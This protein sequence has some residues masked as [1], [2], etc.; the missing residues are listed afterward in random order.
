[1]NYLKTNLT[2]PTATFVSL[3]ALTLSIGMQQVKALD[4]SKKVSTQTPSPSLPSSSSFKI[5]Q[6]NPIYG[7]WKLRFSNAGVIYESV[8]R[9]NGYSGIMLTRYYDVNYRRSVIVQQTMKLSSSAKGLVI[10]GYNPVY[11]GTKT[12]HPTYSPDNFL[13]QI[14][15]NGSVRF[16][17]CDDARRC[18]PV[19]IF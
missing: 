14:N 4:S 3:I 15:P 2:A 10:L 11:A 16:A 1:M 7:Q 12:R 8:L 6:S 19:E 18:S 13:F 17:T 5:A 9:M